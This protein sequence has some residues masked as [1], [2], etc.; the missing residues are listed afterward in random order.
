MATVLV[1]PDP[2]EPVTNTCSTRLFTL[3]LA[4]T[5]GIELITFPISTYSSFMDSTMN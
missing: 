5:G 4:L 1:F 2:V 3:I